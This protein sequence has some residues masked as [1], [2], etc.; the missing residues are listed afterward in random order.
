MFPISSRD[1]CQGGCLLRWAMICQR[2][3]LTCCGPCLPAGGIR[4]PRHVPSSCD[5][6]KAP[7]VMLC[8]PDLGLPAVGPAFGRS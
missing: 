3:A 5:L 2:A 8:H 6:G 1:H 4:E 7:D